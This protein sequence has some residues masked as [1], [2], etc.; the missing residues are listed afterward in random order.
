MNRVKH[1]DYD[2]T[3]GSLFGG[4]VRLAGPMFVSAALQNIQSVI[5]LFWVGK[6][7]SNAVAALALSGSILMMLFPLLMGMSTGTVAIIS[8]RV[9]EEDHDAASNAAAQSLLL[10]LALGVVCSILGWLLAPGLCGML[11]AS[12]GVS[13]PAHSYLQ[14][15]F[16]GSFTVFLL[17]IGNSILQ[18]AGNTV[19]PMCVMAT[20]NILNMI[21]DPIFIFGIGIFP[22]MG[23]RGAALA[24]VVSQAT[25]ALIVLFLLTGGTTRIHIHA[26]RWRVK[27]KIAMELFRIGIPSSAQMLSRSLMALVLMKIVAASGTAA[28]AA[29]G[30]GLR[31]HMLAL[32]PTFALGN[33]AATMVG[34]NLGARRPRRATAAGWLAAGAGMVIMISAGVA[35][36]VFSPSLIRVFDSD[37]AVVRTGTSYM[38]ITSAFYVFT[39][40]AIILG[41]ALHGAG[42][43]VPPMVFTIISLWGIQ[44]PL[45]MALSRLFD[46]PT[47]GIWWAIAAAITIHGLLVTAW[48]IIGRWKKRKV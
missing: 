4:L 27:W 39:G 2:L 16:L 15:T 42:D 17:F 12:P 47:N 10:G 24:T 25:A 3:S 5:D 19:I 22:R 9:G 8:R 26:K 30:I 40:L 41:R 23:V 18:A 29:Y 13:G 33:A 7:G 43:T 44:V 28:I 45:A 46:P 21:L 1:S 31:F 6:L 34:Q 35:M 14:I 36:M 38:R 11:G 20:A 32:M 48:F 37:A